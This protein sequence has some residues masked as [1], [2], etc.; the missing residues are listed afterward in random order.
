MGVSIYAHR[1]YGKAKACVAPC[2]TAGLRPATSDCSLT[3]SDKLFRLKLFRIEMA[4]LIPETAYVLTRDPA[5]DDQPVDS[6]LQ[7]GCPLN[8]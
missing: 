4:L 7:S 5:A 2:Q 8:V 3:I 1:S 6:P